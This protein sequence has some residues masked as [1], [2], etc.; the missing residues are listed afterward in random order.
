MTLVANA[1][2]AIDPTAQ[3]SV[4]AEDV[5]K[6]TW[7]DGNPNGITAEQITV[8]QAELQAAH[9]NDYSRKRREAY[10][11]AGCTI[12]ALAVATFESVFS[13]DSSAAVKL[14]IA[15]DKIREAI[16]KP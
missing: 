2:L 5:N 4:T 14:A 6:I 9:D 12:E 8:K 3:V 7:H 13:D 15:R 1:I 11:A 16:P 10:D